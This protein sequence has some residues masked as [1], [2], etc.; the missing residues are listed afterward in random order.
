MISLVSSDTRQSQ[1]LNLRLSSEG[2][3]RSAGSVADDRVVV[4][5]DG[6]ARMTSLRKRLFTGIPECD[7]EDPEATTYCLTGSMFADLLE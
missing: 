4:D 7:T 6:L 3:P 1:D 5:D 2:S